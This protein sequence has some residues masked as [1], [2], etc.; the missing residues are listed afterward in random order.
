MGVPS[1]FLP[2][3]RTS[4]AASSCVIFGIRSLIGSKDLMGRLQPEVKVAVYGPMVTSV[5]TYFGLGDVAPQPGSAPDGHQATRPFKRHLPRREGTNSCTPFSLR[6]GHHFG[7]DHTGPFDASSIRPM[8]AT[9]LSARNADL[10]SSR[11]TR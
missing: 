6:C 2:S 8:R 5:Q 7:K 3:R 9:R 11:L 10:I 1:G 4:V